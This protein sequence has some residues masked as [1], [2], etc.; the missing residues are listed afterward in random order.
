M[1]LGHAFTAGGYDGRVYEEPMAVELV[2]HGIPY[3]VSRTVEIFYDS[4][5]KGSEHE[6][7][8]TC[9]AGEVVGESKALASIS[10]ANEAQLHAYL[11]TTGQRR[12][13]LI[14][15][16]LDKPEPE[17]GQISLEDA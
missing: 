15:F 16:P 6:L 12:G 7:D 4:Q 3:E 14:N 10:R 9:T 5:D 2:A 1:V 11:R 17:I 8:F 13:V